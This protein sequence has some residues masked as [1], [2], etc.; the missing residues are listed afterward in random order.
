MSVFYRYMKCASTAAL[1]PCLRWKPTSSWNMSSARG[2]MLRRND[3]MLNHILQNFVKNDVI[4]EFDATFTRYY[5]PRTMLPAQYIKESV[6]KL[7]RC[8][9]LAMSTL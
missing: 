3:R 4:A 8:E 2:E 6:R 7:L 1:N 5:Q 9:K